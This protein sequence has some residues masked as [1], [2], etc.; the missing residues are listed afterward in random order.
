MT[1]C[2]NSGLDDRP[3]I[4]EV[5]PAYIRVN[6]RLTIARPDVVE[7][8]SDGP[9]RGKSGALVAEVRFFLGL[10]RPGGSLSSITLRYRGITVVRERPRDS[11]AVPEQDLG[12]GVPS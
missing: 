1:G 8:R 10:G 4:E 5:L 9:G 12:R 2:G 3:S 6:Q 7:L 11:K